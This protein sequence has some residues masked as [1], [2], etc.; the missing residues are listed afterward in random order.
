MQAKCELVSLRFCH[1]RVGSSTNQFYQTQKVGLL[2]ISSS[3]RILLFAVEP[4][5]L[6]VAV[7]IVY[8]QGRKIAGL[9]TI[10]D[11][12][13][14]LLLHQDA[15]HLQNE[16]CTKLGGDAVEIM[17]GRLVAIELAWLV[18]L[19]V[20]Q[21]ADDYGRHGKEQRG[22]VEIVYHAQIFKA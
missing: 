2:K 13:V 12:I 21:G 16:V 5:V 6:A 22:L 8:R 9:N 7:A 3:A 18:I 10:D 17:V 4:E 11:G 20:V 1:F 14:I 15:V 19:G